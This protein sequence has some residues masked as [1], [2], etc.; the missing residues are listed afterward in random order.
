M[1][2]R[3]ADYAVRCVLYLAAHHGELKSVKDIAGPMEIPGSFLAKIL[4][5]LLKA[6]FVLSTRGVGGGFRLSRDPSEITLYDVVGAIDGPVTMSK[7]AVDARSCNR[8]DTCVV[9][10]VWIE[11]R[12]CVETSLKAQTFDKLA[13]QYLDGNIV[14]GVEFGKKAK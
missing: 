14:R 3:E 9:H 10:P 13:E 12:K 1:V 5:R 2:T 6:G 4:Q 7:C 11:V 8:S